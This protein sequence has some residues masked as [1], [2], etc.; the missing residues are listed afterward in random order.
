MEERGRD[1][2]NW[3]GKIKRNGSGIMMWLLPRQDVES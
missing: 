1:T 2:G 3:V